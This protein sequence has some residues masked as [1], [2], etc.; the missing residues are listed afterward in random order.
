MK[1]FHELSSTIPE[2]RKNLGIQAIGFKSKREELIHKFKAW[3]Q[4]K[5]GKLSPFA[6]NYLAEKYKDDYFV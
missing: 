6:K 4:E 3:R 5:S 1:K 2:Y